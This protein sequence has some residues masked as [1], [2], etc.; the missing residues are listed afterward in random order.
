M[1]EK[2]LV[3]SQGSDRDP[4]YSEQMLESNGETMPFNTFFHRQGVRTLDGDLINSCH[5]NT[6]LTLSLAE[7]VQALADA[8]HRV[9]AIEQGGLYFAK[10]SLEAANMPT[11]PVIS[12]P[13]G[14]GIGG[15]AAFLAP[16][17][18]PGTAAIAGVM[19]G[20]YQTAANVAARI[21][22]STFK[23]VYLSNPSEKLEKTLANLR[24]PVLGRLGKEGVSSIKDVLVLGTADFRY[25]PHNAC[26][27]ELDALGNNLGIFAP[28]E[29]KER[30][31]PV[32]LGEYSKGLKNSVMVNRDENLAYFAAKVMAAYTPEIAAQLKADA[33]KKAAS[34]ADRKITLDAFTMGEK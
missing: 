13:L 7:Q 28:I 3:Q 12:I 32:M 22:N 31:M 15:L 16:Y 23:G 25:F 18:P 14:D 17:V 10:P 29:T 30:E 11:V 19:T 2:L 1:A 20:E 6:K 21:L 9:V 27:N 26:F 34:Y 5:G 8:G 4:K 33:N 24:V